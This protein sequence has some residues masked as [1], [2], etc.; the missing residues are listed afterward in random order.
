MNPTTLPIPNRRFFGRVGLGFLAFVVYG[1][2]VPFTFAPMPPERAAAEFREVLAGPV[3]FES[4]SDWAANVLLMV[5]AAFCLAGALGADRPRTGW[6]G[7]AVL[8]VP[9]CLSVSVLVEFGQLFIP[10]RVSSLNDIVAQGLGAVCGVLL[11]GLGGQRLTDWGRRFGQGQ[12]PTDAALRLLPAYLGLLVVLHLLPLDLTL[13]PAAIYHKF[14]DGRVNLVPFR[15][16]GGDPYASIQKN[17]LTVVY[18]A[19]LGSLLAGLSDPR[20]RDRRNAGA[21]LGCAFLFVVLLN[22]LKLLV[23]SRNFDITDV[24]VGILA[25]VGGRWLRRSLG[26]RAAAT[27]PAWRVC[28]LGAWLVFLA[29][30]TWH[31][32]DFDL[33]LAGQ[34]LRDLPTL[35][36]ADLRLGSELLALQ[37]V[38]EKLTL[39]LLL[40]VLL[41][42]WTPLPRRLSWL[43]ALL[44]GFLV[45]LALEAGQLVLASRTASLSD[46]YVET[47]G[48]VLGGLIARRMCAPAIREASW[49]RREYDDG[50][51]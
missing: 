7:D 29:F 14:K 26:D 51:R 23:V 35:P 42:P 32:F 12:D 19:G 34:R 8:V 22:G 38:V 6:I 31:P 10:D 13:S 1:S 44:G 40:G 49:P 24:V 21:V 28:L 46:V 16:S 45:A 36:F 47:A 33:G 20:R 4:R 5:P 9:A 43:P 11:W 39:Y 30:A 18:F 17:I 27:N 50:E 48:A 15:S 41:T 2:W 25:V 3:R 37:N